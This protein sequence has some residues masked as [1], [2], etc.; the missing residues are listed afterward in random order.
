MSDNAK[1]KS[2]ENLEKGMLEAYIN[3]PNLAK[4]ELDAAGYHVNSLVNDGLNL[5]KQHQFKTQ[6]TVN[7]IHLQD[8]FVKA[9][10][11]LQA[12]AKLNKEDALAILAQ[13]QV[14]V[15]YRNITNF[16]EDELNEILK[17]VDVIK[18]I[19]ELEKKK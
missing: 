17:D 6:A 1:H 13:Y 12:K 4:E 18:L 3:N 5:I 15:Q 16:S 14:K 2:L 9:K 19:E 11:L 8:L 7:R 10:A